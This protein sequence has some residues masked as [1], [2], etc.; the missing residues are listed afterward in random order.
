MGKQIAELVAAL[1]EILLPSS[2][3]RAIVA[4]FQNVVW[5]GLEEGL[6]AEIQDVLG[7]L[8]YDFDFFDPDAASRSDGPEYFGHDRLVR[9]VKEGL[10][11]LRRVG[12][13]I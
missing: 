11:R 2:D 13:E 1:N 9:V 8:A 4:R 6:S 3:R 10:E 5:L 7:D 12:V